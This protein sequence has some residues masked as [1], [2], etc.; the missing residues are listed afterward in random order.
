[1]NLTVRN[2]ASL[3]NVSE[4]TIYRWIKQGALPV[5]KVQDQY[6]FNRAELLELAE[7]FQSGGIYYRVEGNNR[8]EV[9]RSV[10]QTLRL[11]EE[12]DQEFLYRV[13][14]AREELGSTAIGQGMAIP[15]VRN[16]LVLHV[17]RPMIGLCFLEKAIDFG[18]LDGEPVRILFTLISPTVRS[19]LH[20]L[21]RLT[22]ALREPSFMEPIQREGSREEIL[23]ALREIEASFAVREKA[24]A[25]SS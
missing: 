13:L 15:H 12:V 11:P 10:V 19:H 3:L 4:K 14:L 25:H 1:M 23:G 6:R 22:Y 7:A 24:E 9:L 5:Y 18:A 21:S 2:A 16:P 17:P 8:E 20:I